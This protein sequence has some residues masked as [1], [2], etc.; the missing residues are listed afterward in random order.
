MTLPLLISEVKQAV[1]FMNQAKLCTFQV[2]VSTTLASTCLSVDT[3]KA[4]RRDLCAAIAGATKL[5]VN[6]FSMADYVRR[7]RIAR[8]LIFS[9]G[10]APGRFGLERLS[11]ET[12]A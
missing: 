4:I 8:D 2:C 1:G 7:R 3:L 11:L 6:D 12:R 5:S 10:H 9:L